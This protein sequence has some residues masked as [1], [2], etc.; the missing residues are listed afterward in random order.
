MAEIIGWTASIVLLVTLGRQI[1]KQAR[2]PE[3]RTV[4]TWLFIGQACAS[5]LFVAYSV[6]LENW[7]F[8]VTNTCLLI[9]A[10]IGHVLTRRR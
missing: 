7:V 10:V 4:S 1:M 3:D 2:R 9:T 5:A 6:M 8:T